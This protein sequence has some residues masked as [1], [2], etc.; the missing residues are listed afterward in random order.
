MP[1]SVS[2]TPSRFS[3]RVILMIEITPH[4]T[5]LHVDLAWFPQPYPPNVFLVHD[6]GHGALIDAGFN[7]DDSFNKR[8]AMLAEAGSPQLDYI[9]TTHHH[10][11]HTAGAQRLRE[12]TGARIVMHVDE[13]PL[14]LRQDEESGDMEIPE[15]QKA[16]REQA[17]KWRE[18]AARAVPDVRVN[19]GDVLTVGGLH[20]RCVHTPG[21]TAGHL[22]LLLQEDN[23]LFSGDNVL[24]VGTAAISPPPHGDMARV[25]PLA[26]EDAG[27]RVSAHLPRP[28]PG[29]EGAASQ[30]PGADRPP[31]AARGPDRRAAREG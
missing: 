4:V 26:Q 3:E 6:G 5:S 31:P 13:E 15:D 18:E 9:I 2:A 20:L 12:A 25:H 16:A 11:D 27:A 28:R 17:R 24:G 10:Y 1:E 23:V 7:D 19:D 29:R 8:I 30:D 14:L 21:H 22:C